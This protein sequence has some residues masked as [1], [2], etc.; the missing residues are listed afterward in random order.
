MDFKHLKQNLAVNLVVL[1]TFLV[2]SLGLGYAFDARPEASTLRQSSASRRIDTTVAAIGVELLRAAYEEGGP[3][4]L[5]A[6]VSDRAIDGVTDDLERAL[7]ENG[8]RVL[9]KDDKTYV[10]G[11]LGNGWRMDL[12]T[13][14]RVAFSSVDEQIGFVSSGQLTWIAGDY[15]TEELIDAQGEAKAYLQEAGR[16]DRIFVE[17]DLPGQVARYSATRTSVARQLPPLVTHEDLKKDKQRQLVARLQAGFDFHR[18]ATDGITQADI[19]AMMPIGL[20]PGFPIAVGA[21]NFSY[22]G[23]AA[24]GAITA[25]HLKEIGI[26]DVI[27]GHSET[28]LITGTTPGA[29]G[30][31]ISTIEQP[32]D[33]YEDVRSKLETA[34]QNGLKVTLCV[35]EDSVI[36]MGDEGEILAKHFVTRQIETALGGFSA[37]NVISVLEAVAYEPI[38]AIGTGKTAA[39]EQIQEMHAT[40]RQWFLEKFGSEVAEKIAI[41]Y[42]G[43]VNPGNAADIFVKQHVD[44]ALIGGASLK[45]DSMAEIAKIADDVGKH[46]GKIMH[47][48]ANW[49][50]QD[51]VT[52]DDIR[53]HLL[54]IADVGLSSTAIRYYLPFTILAE[55]SR[56]VNEAISPS[57]DEVKKDLRNV[58]HTIVLDEADN[59]SF[60][61]AGE[62][63]SSRFTAVTASSGGYRYEGYNYEVAEGRR[64]RS[65]YNNLAMNESYMEM[66]ATDID[67]LRAYRLKSI[68][69]EY[70]D[71]SGGFES[72]NLVPREV[73]DLVNK[74]DKMALDM[75]KAREAKKAADKLAKENKKVIFEATVVNV[76]KFL[77]PKLDEIIPTEL[78]EVAEQELRKLVESGLLTDYK[79]KVSAGHIGIISTR[80]NKNAVEHDALIPAAMVNALLGVLDKAKQMGIYRGEDLS[81]KS[82]LEQ[83]RALEIRRPYVPLKYTERAADPFGV[84]WASNTYVGAFNLLVIQILTDPMYNAGKTIDPTMPP[85]VFKI[86]DSFED[87]EYTLNG[88]TEGKKLIA[89][90][91]QP[92]RYAI[93]AAYAVEG[94][95]KVPSDEP[96]VIVTVKRMADDGVS[97]VG[98]FSP[99]MIARG[100][101][102]LPAWGELLAPMGTAM[103]IITYGGDKT[104]NIVALRPTNIDDANKIPASQRKGL[105]LLTGFG[106]QSH[107]NGYF[108]ISEDIGGHQTMAPAREN[109]DRWAKLFFG[110]DIPEYM[111]HITRLE[112]FLRPHI[113]NRD[114]QVVATRKRLDSRFQRNPNLKA[115][116]KDPLLQKK[117][118]H[119]LT[120][121]KADIGSVPGHYKPHR[122]TI[123]SLNHIKEI[124]KVYGFKGASQ[125]LNLTR[126]ITLLRTGYTIDELVSKEGLYRKSGSEVMVQKV[127]EFQSSKKV[128]DWDTGLSYLSQK[129]REE[130]AKVE[131]KYQGKTEPKQLK[132]KEETIA[133]VKVIYAEMESVIIS[134]RDAQVNY[135]ELMKKV[136]A[137]SRVDASDYLVMSEE[138]AL[139]QKVEAVS[140]MSGLT[141]QSAKKLFDTNETIRKALGLTTDLAEGDKILDY[142]PAWSGGDDSQ[143]T[144]KHKL[145]AEESNIH[146]FAFN[147]LW[148]AADQTSYF[149]PYGWKQDILVDRLVS[150][151]I[152]GAGPGYAELQM[153]EGEDALVFSADKCAPG[154]FTV[155]ILGMIRQ[156]L[157]Q[158]KFVNGVIAEIW[159]INNRPRAFFD[160]SDPNQ[161]Q[162][163]LTLLSSPEEFAIKR[164]WTVVE[165]GGQVVTDVAGNEKRIDDIPLIAASTERLVL[166][167]GEYVG[168]D[169]PTLLV[170]IS[171][172]A[173]ETLAMEDVINIFQYPQVTLGFMRGS[174]VGPLVP[175]T[176]PSF[177]FGKDK[178]WKPEATPHLFDGP[179]PLAG[180]ILSGDQPLS[181]AKDVFETVP[182]LQ[183]AIEQGN[184]MTQ[185]LRRQGWAPPHKVE[186]PDTEYTTW[187]QVMATI[188]AEGRAKPASHAAEEQFMKSLLALQ[189]EGISH[190]LSDDVIKVAR[191]AK[192]RKVILIKA[193]VLRSDPSLILALQSINEQINQNLGVFGD[194]TNIDANAYQF[195]LV[196][197]D[198]TLRTKKD[199]DEFFAAIASATDNGVTVNKDMFAKIVTQDD[200]LEGQISDPA[201]LI[202]QLKRTGIAQESIAAFV[203]PTEW[204]SN[205]KLLQ[206]QV[207]FNVDAQDGKVAF[208][209]NALFSAVEAVATTDKFLPSPMQEKFDVALLPLGAMEVRQQEVVEKVEADILAY[210]VTMSE[211]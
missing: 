5:K 92:G 151:N 107:D 156:A 62:A 23:G 95:A 166:T 97:Q 202:I 76:A 143:L 40:I 18:E 33:T 137:D 200:M 26:R 201:D 130:L 57:V 44:G 190:K 206:G 17:E 45:A 115:G 78:I 195:V 53:Q 96:V 188:E 199:V 111:D 164:I 135:E 68:L 182:W 102:G 100:Q 181:E 196:A 145:L 67:A 147:A 87:K 64:P 106:F 161:Y 38:W 46:K 124:A 120:N 19:N 153:W 9:E 47:V 81:K 136:E 171:K 8:I 142:I 105:S 20:T 203:G 174:H 149:K 191:D 155:P 28:R 193:S 104:R 11:V 159:D 58:R 41:L 32:G 27:V 146:S 71:V 90:A 139:P 6:L 65:T 129:L 22:K 25:D 61:Y 194:A 84:F 133:A 184:F 127:R 12:S 189:S 170:R 198:V 180:L 98:D 85:F 125:F 167:A 89:V 80:Q 14:E 75:W 152:Q 150:G 99:I 173:N 21:E 121:I 4:A 60:Y 126:V 144:M 175:G 154:A 165:S 74:Y 103:P 66:A 177:Y 72:L 1:V 197:D 148:Y 86:W 77:D 13:G 160:L 117:G 48:S 34:L 56:I 185:V 70:I 179:P 186:G 208:A 88:E 43:S 183:D 114:D 113:Y 35:G 59:P 168:K 54:A 51:V 39:P 187:P 2:S 42:G 131:K 7:I 109:A 176:Q 101:S 205:L 207:A 128:T 140:I 112:P 110:E 69:H 192:N 134:L 36:R 94:W 204:T 79:L 50:A 118:D 178:E 15:T 31:M 16:E 163:A 49:K 209:S 3:K 82:Y 10:I 73:L 119:A 132:E 63:G 141:A 30:E 116:E 211:I 24:T 210:R 157:T 172:N 138:A 169:D 122:V 52:R 123:S 158:G 55:S 37:D 29:T 91:N 162:D 93:V 108:G 83:A